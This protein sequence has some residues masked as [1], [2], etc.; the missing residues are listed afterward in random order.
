MVEAWVLLR[1]STLLVLLTTTGGYSFLPHSRP[2]ARS[3]RGHRHYSSAISRTRLASPCAIAV[4]RG[5]T[6]DEK[7]GE[8]T[9]RRSS[10]S[11]TTSNRAHDTAA[12]DGAAAEGSSRGEW[13]GVQQEQ[14][15][16]ASSTP[17]AEGKVSGTTTAALPGAGGA[18]TST[19][20]PRRGGEKKA[21][22]A[23]KGKG[24]KGTKTN[25]SIG[26]SNLDTIIGYSAKSGVL[27]G[28][29]PEKVLFGGEQETAQSSSSK[30]K[31]K[32]KAEALAVAVAA[33]ASEVEEEE[34]DDEA[35]LSFSARWRRRINF[36]ARTVQIWAFL[37][38]VLIKLLRQ[39]LVQMD[40]A[41]MSA[42]RRKL[43]RYLCRAFLKLGPTF[44]KI[45]Q[46]L[47]TRVDL[48]STE[49]IEELQQLQDNVPGF[50]GAKAV[51]IIE[52][53]LGAP[54]DQLF[55]KFNS[56]SLAA[57]SLGQ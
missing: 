16:A 10:S 42:R 32:A 56:T 43:G 14:R 30:A 2:L 18:T 41:R 22:S 9:S 49:Y 47:S 55:D 15:G 17:P 36:A 19:T 40:E 46:L 21:K 53:E 48:L 6:V 39:K 7:E 34:E 27:F 1:A 23:K 51:S 28:G 44:I 20:R 35:Q 4:D 11:D 25:P 3:L 45:G 12:P 57:A 29:D 13:Y 33:A 31:A 50:G 52:R 8:P 5:N 54:I 26:K 38:H 37:F 24:A